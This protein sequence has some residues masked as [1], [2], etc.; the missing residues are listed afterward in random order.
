MGRDPVPHTP[1]PGLNKTFSLTLLPGN[2]FFSQIHLFH[3]YGSLLKLEDAF[4]PGI[5]LILWSRGV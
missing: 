5:F 4:F 3:F 2:I 1:C